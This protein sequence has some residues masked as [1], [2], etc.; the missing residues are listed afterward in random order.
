VCHRDQVCS[1]LLEDLLGRVA[2]Q[3]EVQA[4]V[5]TVPGAR[6]RVCVCV[7]TC[8]VCAEAAAQKA[9]SAFT[10][11]AR[12]IDARTTLAALLAPLNNGMTHTRTCLST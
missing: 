3:K 5:E 9:Y 12:T 11:L 4:I 10:L 8:D 2:E 6:A 1:I 7:L